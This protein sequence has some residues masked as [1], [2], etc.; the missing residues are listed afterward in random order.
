MFRI[1]DT[2]PSAASEKAEEPNMDIGIPDG[3]PHC[4][5]V[6]MVANQIRNSMFGSLPLKPRKEGDP[7]TIKDLMDLE[8][9]I[10]YATFLLMI[11]GRQTVSNVSM[12]GTND[13]YATK[14]TDRITFINGFYAAWYN[15]EKTWNNKDGSKFR[16]E[17]TENGFAAA[18]G[19][20]RATTI[21]VNDEIFLRAVNNGQGPK[22]NNKLYYKFVGHQ[23]I[24]K[25]VDD[26]EKIINEPH[27]FESA[28]GGTGRL[29][30]SIVRYCHNG[31]R[32]SA[33][34]VASRMVTINKKGIHLETNRRNQ[35]FSS[36]SK[37]KRSPSTM[38]T[39]SASKRLTYNSAK[40]D[41]TEASDEEY[42]DSD[43]REED[44]ESKAGPKADHI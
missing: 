24:H 17:E 23:K 4:Q 20:L 21:G 13:W 44:E 25:V 8:I 14:V 7:Q 43:N 11:V 30:D 41:D 32:T 34:R 5:N 10:A 28:G 19:S 36:G 26:L 9:I 27:T 29:Y 33:L 37:R 1:L 15:I 39:G 35:R 16:L 3:L 18:L 2:K 6:P 31:D 40:E 38:A 42:V 12:D 22:I